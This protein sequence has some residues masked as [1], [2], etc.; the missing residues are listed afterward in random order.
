MEVSL[1]LHRF[2]RVNSED[3]LLRNTLLFGGKGV[4]REYDDFIIPA[5]EAGWLWRTKNPIA[6]SAVI[7]LFL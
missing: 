3:Q 7:C 1:N 4:E 6:Y 2:S 5:N